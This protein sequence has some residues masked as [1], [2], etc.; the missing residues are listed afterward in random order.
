MRM[1]TTDNSIK[2]NGLA[3]NKNYTVSIIPFYRVS[4]IET[5]VINGMPH[6]KNITT[7]PNGKC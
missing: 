3:P 5:P 2:F 4:N 7:A 1:I 6:E